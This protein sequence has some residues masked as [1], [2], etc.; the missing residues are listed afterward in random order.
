MGK[1]NE[2]VIPWYARNLVGNL[3]STCWLGLSGHDALTTR[4][5]SEHHDFYDLTLKNWD[6]N[7]AWTLDAKYDTIVCTRCAYF[8]RDPSD[9]L[10]RCIASLNSGGRLI[11]DWGLGDHWRFPYKVGWHRSDKTEHEY[12]DYGS[13]RSYLNSFCGFSNMEQDVNV[14]RF[15]SLIKKFGYDDERTLSDIIHAEVPSYVDDIM[16]VVTANIDVDTLCLWPDAPQ[17]YV[18]YVISDI[19]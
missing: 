1:S 17:L 18:L 3:G 7:A 6:I 5:K 12:C 11:V 4:V 14:M 13:T 9:F 8:S 10:T 16:S 15:R 2:I 19:R